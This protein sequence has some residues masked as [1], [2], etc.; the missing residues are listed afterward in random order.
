MGRAT[1]PALAA[2]VSNAGGF[3][4]PGMSLRPLDDMRRVTRETRELTERPFGVNFILRPSY[5]RAEIEAGV[6]VCLDEGA[7]VVSFF[8]DEASQYV[9]MVHAAGALV[10]YTVPSAAAA[11]RAVDAGVD[12]I[13]AQ[14]WEAGGHVRGEVA[15]L[16]LVPRVVDAVAPTPVIAAGGIADGRGVAAVLALGAGGAWLGTRFVA[17]EEAGV[18]P[19]YKAKLLE[20]VETDTILSC[21]FDI[22][23][24]DAPC[25]T[26]CNSTVTQWDA[27]GRP[28]S[29]Q[30]PGEGDVVAHWADGRPVVRY[31]T[32]LPYAGITG[33]IEAMELCVGQGV[34]LVTRI[35]PAGRWPP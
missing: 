4:M 1:N 21:L 31:A 28:P 14:G 24:P 27:A 35:Q 19:W 15:T 11:R 26:L 2:A 16:P 23:W 20:T 6:K 33:D 18:H 25:R 5:R 22:G 9:D 32:S 34:G 8:W 17:S 3:G 10:M 29:G 7:P 12:I 30:R 13:V